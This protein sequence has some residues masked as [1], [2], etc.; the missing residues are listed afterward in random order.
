MKAFPGD[1][2]KM[3]SPRGRKV[4]AGKDKRACGALAE[5]RFFNA[6]DLLDASSARA[7]PKLL[8]KAFSP[9]MV[10]MA[11]VAPD[12][13]SATVMAGERLPKTVRMLTTQQNSPETVEAAK[14]CGLLG[15]LQSPAYHDFV[16]ALAGRPLKGPDTLQVLCYRPGDYAGPHTDNHPEEPA[17]RNGYVDTHLTF[18]TPGVEHQYLVYEREGHLSEIQS[19]V[20]TGSVTA[21]RLPFWHYTTPLVTRSK[22]TRRW[23]VL[24]TF[25]YA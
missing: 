25:L 24:G 14:E 2:S 22:A 6:A 1:F 17:A 8:A 11:R 16:Q 23:L 15:M 20:A 3:L 21:Y 19:I 5:Q 12:P 9:L 13:M 7:A 4:L 18:C 10:E